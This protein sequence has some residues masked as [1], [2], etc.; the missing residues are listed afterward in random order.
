MVPSLV[1]PRDPNGWHT[2]GVQDGVGMRR[3]RC[4]DVWHDGD[5][6]VIDVSFQDSGTSPDARPNS[7]E[8][9][10]IHEYHL[11]ARAQ[12]GI[13]TDLKVDAHILP[14][15]ECPG[16]IIHAQRMIGTPLR[17]LR[18]KVLESLPGTLGCTHLNDVLR[19]MA[20]VPQLLKQQ[21]AL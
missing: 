21:S 19:S 6:V 11:M 15:Q 2:L 16:A 1:N 17:D 3:A 13:L 20:E 7:G 12:D 5:D 9:I 4:I 8:R 10:A 14:F 18:N